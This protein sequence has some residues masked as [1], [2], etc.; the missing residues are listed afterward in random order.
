MIVNHIYRWAAQQPARTAIIHDDRPVS[1]AAFAQGIDAARRFLLPHDMPVGMTAVV[2]VHHYVRQWCVLLALRSL[3]MNTICVEKLEDVETLRLGNIGAVVTTPEDAARCRVT[4]PKAFGRRITIVPDKIWRSAAGGAPAP[5]D[6][7]ER[8]YGGHILYTSGTTGNHKKVLVEGRH[9]EALV[10]R[11]VTCRDMLPDSIAHV[12]SFSLWSGIGFKL[13]LSAWHEGA[14]VVADQSGDAARNVFRHQ[15]T[16]VTLPPGMAF[17]LVAQTATVRRPATMPTISL[18]GGF[19]SPKLIKA[20]RNAKFGRIRVGFGATECSHILRSYVEE[21]D[22]Q[23]AWL[24]PVA[25]RHVEIVDEEDRACATGQEGMLRVRLLEHDAREYLDD[26]ETSA[27]VFRD[28]WFYPGDLAVRREDGRIR[29][30]GRAGDV[31]NLRGA[32]VA[33]APLE[34]QMRQLLDIEN[35]CLFQGVDAAGREELVVAIEAEVLPD[36]KL[37]DHVTVNLPAFERVRFEAVSQFPR[38]SSGLQK[39]KRLELRKR[40]FGAG[41][42]AGG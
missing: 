33:A 9:E 24:E 15:P 36:Q 27:S 11:C 25:D 34:Q 14:T 22:E 7:P 37:I 41:L 3:G 31:L 18:G 2:L 35:V 26:P 8:P 21:E 19:V 40:V 30:L 5:N 32:K 17:D 13:P 23:A 20:L 4:R 42:E 39:I 6:D 1:Y 29:I 38:A 10:Q 16:I 28:G 12:L